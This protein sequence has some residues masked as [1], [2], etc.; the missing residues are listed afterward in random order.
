[1]IRLGGLGAAPLRDGAH[2]DEGL[3]DRW[4]LLEGGFRWS[5]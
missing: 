4:V 1:V 5:L 3:T 2:P